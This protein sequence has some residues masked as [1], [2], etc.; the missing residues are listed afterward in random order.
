MSSTPVVLIVSQ[1]DFDLHAAAVAAKLHEMGVRV[2]TLDP[3]ELCARPV[4]IRFGPGIAARS[5]IPASERVDLAA[6]QSVLYRRPNPI[7][8]DPNVQAAYREVVATEWTSFTSGVWELIESGSLWVSHPARIRQ[9]ELKIHQLD[10]ARRVGLTIPR[11]LVTNDIAEVKDFWI[12]CGGSVVFKK[13]R[14]HGIT[15]GSYSAIFSTKRLLSVADL[16][17]DELRVCPV[18]FQE[19][20]PK[21]LDVRIVVIARKV[22]GFTID[23]QQVDTGKVDYRAAGDRIR[24]MPHATYEVGRLTAR[25]LCDMTRM[26]G[27]EFGVYDFV[28]T[29]DDRLV[30]LELNPNGQWLWLQLATRVDLAGEVARLLAGMEQ[31]LS[32]TSRN[33]RC[34]E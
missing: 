14:S 30:F 6:I 24:T 26:L 12:D 16:N 29:A 22:F 17:P 25:R 13:L 1:I 11:T 7:A 9:A 34:S 15:I 28:L 18:I 27:L 4:S 8:E 21:G 32:T 31:P 2:A 5:H 20:M 10:L 33:F 23:A 3:P 19:E